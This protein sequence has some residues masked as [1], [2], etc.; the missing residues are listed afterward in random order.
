MRRFGWMMMAVVLVVLGATTAFAIHRSAPPNIVSANSAGFTGRSLE[1]P[2]PKDGR[3][4]PLVAV[5]ADNAGTETTDFVIP[6]GVLKESRA[7]DVV[8]VSTEAGAV[9]LMPA[10]RVRTDAT[11][12][13]FDASTPAGA[14]FVIVPAMHRYSNPAM[15]GW[16]R[17]QAEKG[18]VVVSICEGA[19][20]IAAAGLL[21]GKEATSHWF[22]L[23][24]LAKTYPTTTWVLD[25][26]YVADGRIMTTTGVTASIPASL[27][28]VEAIAGRSAAEATAKR[29]GVVGWDPAHD[30]AAFKLTAGRIGTVAGNWLAFWEHESVEIPVENGFDEIAVA[31]AADAWSRTYRSNAVATDASDLVH[32]RHGLLLEPERAVTG[33]TFVVVRDGGATPALEGALQGIFRRYGTSTADFVAQQLEYQQR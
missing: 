33:R 9:H 8:T 25:R 4:R 19:R 16:V 11:I 18:A 30:S 2:P 1:V 3:N 15:L 28:L 13:Q 23:R 7:A 20:V 31:L 17:A 6:Y 26:R 14:D 32:S 5:L 10:L 12:A 21:D 24:K 29:L 22:A 27:A